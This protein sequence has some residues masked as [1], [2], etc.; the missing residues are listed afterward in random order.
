MTFSM[1]FMSL[2]YLF[3]ACSQATP[4]AQV[5][6]QRTVDTLPAMTFS[7]AYIMGKFEPA[8]HPDFALIAPN[9]A[10]RTG[11]YMRKDAYDAFRRMH[12][13]AQ[14]EGV[15]LFIVS[16]ARNF[17]R[18]QEIWEAKWTG[19]RAVD[20]Q[21]IAETIPDPVKRA[22]KILEFSSMPG[23]SRHHWGTDIDINALTDSYFT[24]G[25]GKKV[26]AWLSAHAAEYGFC[27]PYTPFGSDRQSGYFEEKWH[28]SYMPVSAVLT[29]QAEKQLNNKM[30]SGFK[31]AET[32]EKIG[33]V[34]KYV[35]GINPNCR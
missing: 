24:Q 19:A 35:L 16:A 18:Q 22:L 17:D 11:M 29:S 28:W 6:Q 9:Y 25:E 23:S 26:Y 21:N 31:G 33:I 15:K 7:L 2:I 5:Q 27:Q 30:I 3:T 4:G 8:T 34:E 10:N 13:A 14:A 32:A 20:G 12:T 1:A